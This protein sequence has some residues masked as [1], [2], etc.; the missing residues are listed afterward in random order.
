M[1]WYGGTSLTPLHAWDAVTAVGTTL[2]DRV[3]TIDLVA[4][5]LPSRG[6][7]YYGFGGNNNPIPFSSPI[8]LPPNYVLSMFRTISSYMVAFYTEL[9]NTSRYYLD[10]EGSGGVYQGGPGGQS[11]YGNVSFSEPMYM[12]VVKTPTSTRLYFNGAWFG[13]VGSAGDADNLVGGIGYSG[14]GNH[15][16]PK[17]SDR[18]HA[19]G[20]WAGEPTIEEMVLLETQCRLAVKSPDP[21]RHL[22]PDIIAPAYTPLGPRKQR[23]ALAS[24]TIHPAFPYRRG[25]VTITGVVKEDGLPVVARVRVHEKISGKAVGAAWTGVDG[26]YTFEDLEPGFEYYI[27]VFDSSGMRNALVKDRVIHLI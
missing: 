20:M 3:G 27:V 4:P 10:V 11:Y 12:A 1:T 18:I 26:V 13:S 24:D 22:L 7:G 17:P 8:T 5:T 21:E 19:I 15:Y 6:I 16:N 23:A 2:T 25:G 9:A 14:D